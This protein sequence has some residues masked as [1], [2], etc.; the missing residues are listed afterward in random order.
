MTSIERRTT[1]KHSLN[2]IKSKFVSLWTRHTEVCGNLAFGAHWIFNVCA[3]FERSLYSY[4]AKQKKWRC[5]TQTDTNPSTSYTEA[6]VY[7]APLLLNHFALMP[8]ILY[9]VQ[10]ICRATIRAKRNQFIICT[11]ATWQRRSTFMEPLECFTVFPLLLPNSFI[12]LS[13][14]DS[15]W[16][17]CTE[18]LNGNCY[19]FRIDIEMVDAF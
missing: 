1:K 5:A 12:F 6:I 19:F 11:F 14:S 4:F 2:V 13:L 9:Y 10:C 18:F 15:F 17:G 7:C 8:C 16:L 3:P